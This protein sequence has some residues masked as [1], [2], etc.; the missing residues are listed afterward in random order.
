MRTFGTDTA[1]MHHDPTRVALLGA[2][3]AAAAA[4]GRL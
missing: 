2:H 4:R 3:H 1:R